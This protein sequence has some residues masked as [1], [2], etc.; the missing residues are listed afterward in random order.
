MWRYY[1]RA[2]SGSNIGGLRIHLIRGTCKALPSYGALLKA[3]TV[4][5]DFV[6]LFVTAAVLF[7]IHTRPRNL[8]ESMERNKNSQKLRAS[9]WSSIYLHWTCCQ[10]HAKKNV[11]AISDVKHICIKGAV[12]FTHQLSD[13]DIQ[14]IAINRKKRATET[15]IAPQMSNRSAC[16]PKERA[17]EWHDYCL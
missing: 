2:P 3:T 11:Y 9:L 14:L 12:G 8:C 6:T 17:E 1:A 16:T 7:H 15:L 4:T 10:I 5:A 13:I